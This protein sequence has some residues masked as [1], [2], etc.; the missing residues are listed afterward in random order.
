M[1][2]PWWLRRERICLQCRRPG[3]DRWVRK[4]PWRREWGNPLQYSCLENP[5]DRGP[6]RL[7][8]MGSQRVRYDCVTNFPFLSISYLSLVS[9]SYRSGAS[10]VAQTIKNLHSGDPGSI[11]RSRR[12]PWRRKWQ[13]TPV[14]LSEESHGWRDLVGYS[15]WSR[16]E[17]DTTERVSLIHFTHLSQY[18]P[19]NRDCELHCLW[20]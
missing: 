5:M 7:Q 6:G 1:G 15:P 18:L 8:S 9:D 14:F 10:L 13:P 12:F 4:I 16:K 3:F 20:S 2:L 11:P 19:C 17:L